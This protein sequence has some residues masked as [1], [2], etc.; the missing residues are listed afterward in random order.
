MGC[1]FGAHIR[2]GQRGQPHGHVLVVDDVGLALGHGDATVAR[3]DHLGG[4]VGQHRADQPLLAAQVG[5]IVDI[6]LRE[7][8]ERQRLRQC[9]W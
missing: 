3:E 2:P 5:L 6:T 7:R 4:R 1:Q 8:Q 9:Q